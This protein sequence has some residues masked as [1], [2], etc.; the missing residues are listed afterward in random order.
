MIATGEPLK[1]LAA[2]R[3]LSMEDEVQAYFQRQEATNSA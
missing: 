2:A 1:V 3:Y